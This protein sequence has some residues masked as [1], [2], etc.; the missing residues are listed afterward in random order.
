M[1]RVGFVFPGQGAVDCAGGGTLDRELRDH[2]SRVLGLDATLALAHPPLFAEARVRQTL[3]VASG[4][5]SLRALAQGGVVPDVVV[6][7]AVGDLGAWSA[8]GGLSAAHAITLA[9]LYG[10]L[11]D[12]TKQAPSYWRGSPAVGAAAVGRAWRTRPSIL[13]YDAL[14]AVLACIVEGR[15][16]TPWV[17]SCNGAIVPPDVPAAPL[18]AR[19]VLEPVDWA[20]ALRTVAAL[21]V[22]DIVILG[23]GRRLRGRIERQLGALVRVHLAETAETVAAT[24]LALGGL[25]A[26]PRHAAP[27]QNAPATPSSVGAA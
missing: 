17:T 6:G 1:R 3:L 7:Q 14:R 13:A 27:L 18:L 25:A 9:A 8:S 10:E 4:L 24:T 12:A 22:T 23:P 16:T 26:A 20:G 2:A 21:G 5:G 11:F 15:R 19:S